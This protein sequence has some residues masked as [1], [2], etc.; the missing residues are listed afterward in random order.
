MP[1][2]DLKKCL[3]AEFVGS[4]HSPCW[5]CTTSY[6]F[7]VSVKKTGEGRTGG[8][9]DIVKV[10]SSGEDPRA[11][12]GLV[13]NLPHPRVNKTKQHC[14]DGHAVSLRFCRPVIP[15]SCQIVPICHPKMTRCQHNLV[16]THQLS[17]ECPFSPSQAPS[18]PEKPH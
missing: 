4:R 9:S 16:M 3:A 13:S 15:S 11:A 8:T 12:G 2:S 14:F 6:K 7:S 17:D 10:R 18:C 1:T 5:I